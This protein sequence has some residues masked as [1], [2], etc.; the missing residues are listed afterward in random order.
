MLKSV[1]MGMNPCLFD[2]C[3]VLQL[4]KFHKGQH[5]LVVSPA[6]LEQH[7]RVKS[8]SRHMIDPSKLVWRPPVFTRQELRF[9]Y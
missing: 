1:L 4:L 2:S 8:K 5:H 3:Q 6:V 9:G 7:E